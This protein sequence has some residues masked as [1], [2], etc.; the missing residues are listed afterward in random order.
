MN[1]L[2]L[3]KQYKDGKLGKPE[4]IR[5]AFELHQQIFQYVNVV[6]ST[7]I[8]E[9]I[10]TSEGVLFLIGKHNISL[11]CPPNESRVAPIEVMNFDKYEP[12]ETQIINLLASEATNIIDIGANIGWYSLY[13]AK[14]YPS[15]KVFSFE[16]IPSSYA[17]LQRNIALNGVGDRVTAFNYGLSDTSGVME[18]FISPASGT[19]ASLKNVSGSL[20]AVSVIGLTL[21]L[22]QWVQN[23]GITPDF[24][25]CD[26][27]GAE[28][29]V[30]KGARKTLGKYCPVIFSELL[31]KWSMP[32]GYYPNDMILFFEKFGYF[33]FGISTSGMRR[34]AIVSEETIETNYVFLHSEAHTNLIE[35]LEYRF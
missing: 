1:F 28:L 14:N 6:R 8:N 18:F 31:R 35:R 2:E 9:I 12:E 21:T 19:N 16:P 20:D 13:F 17:Y 23:Y 30:F 26:V 32:F 22:D 3:K 27:E 15:V 33:C 4:F 29:L 34:M 25:K 7:D 10:I 5:K 11:Y 24:I